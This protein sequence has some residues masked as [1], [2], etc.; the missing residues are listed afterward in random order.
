MGR[1]KNCYG[2]EMIC[3]YEDTRDIT[4]LFVPCVYSNQD[5]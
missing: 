4:L 1:R 3:I 5:S 2:P